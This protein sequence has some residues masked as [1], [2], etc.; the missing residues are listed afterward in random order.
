ME[1]L[2]PFVK[3]L[4]ETLNLDYDEVLSNK[5]LSPYINTENACFY[6]RYRFI[7]T[8]EL[9][10]LFLFTMAKKKYITQSILIRKGDLYMTLAIL[11]IAD[12]KIEYICTGFVP[13]SQD[14]ECRTY[15]F[16]FK[17]Y[18]ELLADI[19]FDKG[20]ADGFFAKLK[21]I[22]D[23]D[24]N[25]AIVCLCLMLLRGVGNNMTVSDYKTIL[26]VNIQLCEDLLLNMDKFFE[27]FKIQYTNKFTTYIFVG[28]HKFMFNFLV[29]LA[30]IPVQQINNLE[31]VKYKFWREYTITKLCQKLVFN[32]VSY[33]YSEVIDWFLFKAEDTNKIFNNEINKLK[34]SQSMLIKEIAG[35]IE[36]ARRKIKGDQRM[37][38]FSDKIKIS[39]DYAEKNLIF[40]DYASAII[41]KNSGR[42]FYSMFYYF[43]LQKSIENEQITIFKDIQ[44]FKYVLLTY[45]YGLYALNL[46]FGIIHNDL[47]L[48]NILINGYYATLHTY[49][50]IERAQLSEY[51]HTNGFN[52]L[53]IHDQLY[54]IKHHFYHGVIIDFGRSLM[55]RK[56]IKNLSITH[57]DY[58]ELLEQQKSRVKHT[59]MIE[60]PEFYAA[61]SK[62]IETLLDKNYDGFML[63]YSAYD[64]YRVSYLILNMFKKYTESDEPDSFYVDKKAIKK[65]HIPF[66]QILVNHC[67]K[68]LTLDILDEDFTVFSNLELIETYFDDCRLENTIFQDTNFLQDYLKVDSDLP[69]GTR[70]FNELPPFIKM[71]E[72]ID[73]KDQNDFLKQLI[74]VTQ[75]YDV[76]KHLQDMVV[77]L[78]TQEERLNE[79]VEI[80]LEHS[81]NAFKEVFKE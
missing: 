29:K 76:E 7:A 8:Q 35:D 69:Y 61:N 55:G 19:T 24:F 20:L 71:V 43:K 72:K 31:H 4:Y 57:N 81:L 39:V 37:I 63:N 67:K 80:A 34:K 52:V 49:L 45:I 47:H 38:E 22:I 1:N 2:G 53:N 23:G 44:A 28:D 59:Y 40:S 51:L 10:S 70:N 18:E 54:I 64:M 77:D 17:N 74:E 50:K 3:K 15:F 60:F 11:F 5:V 75:I 32:H 73:V 58:K 12:G 26:N 30:L 6:S 36:L 27:I 66:L 62:L 14:A 9:V 41:M 25:I 42:S 13:F 33:Y 56:I 68:K 79:Y 16:S 78:P 65:D 21:L 46:H 48:N